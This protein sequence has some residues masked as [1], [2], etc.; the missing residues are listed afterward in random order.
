MISWVIV[1]DKCN[2]EYVPGL[3][4]CTCKKVEEEQ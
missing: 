4:I 3:G 1:C 2:S